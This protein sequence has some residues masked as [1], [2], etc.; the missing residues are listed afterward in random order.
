MKE[1]IP[2]SV[3]PVR[4]DLLFEEPFEVSSNRNGY[5]FK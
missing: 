3:E 5:S 2:K 4:I 1:M